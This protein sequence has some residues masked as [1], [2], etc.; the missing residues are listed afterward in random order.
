MT[1]CL[2]NTHVIETERLVLR[3][4]VAGDWPQFNAMLAS[5]RAGF[6]RTAGYDL[7]QTWRSFGHL[8][9]HWVLRGFGMFVWQAKGDPTGL[10]MTGPWFP[11]TWPEREIGWSVWNP[12]AEGKGM[13]FEAAC[14]ARAYAYRHLGWPTAVSYIHPD[15][16]RSRRLAER[17]GAAPDR[18]ATPM[19]DC[20]VYRHPAPAPCDTDSTPGFRPTDEGTAP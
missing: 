14:A 6:I 15:N 8:I 20:L 11:E 13:A 18:D 3:A 4:P 19:G 12:Q 7:A 17:L 9:G 5:D 2:A 10:G 1:P 16:L